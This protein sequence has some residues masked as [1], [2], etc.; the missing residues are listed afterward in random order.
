MKY[1]KGIHTL[2][3]KTSPGLD[4]LRKAVNGDPETMYLPKTLDQRLKGSVFG[5]LVTTL[6]YVAA[7]VIFVVVHWASTTFNI[8]LAEIFNTLLGPLK[9][10]G[11]GTVSHALWACL[12]PIFAALLAAGVLLWLDRRRTRQVLASPEGPQRQERS[13]RILR[14]RRMGVSVTCLLMAGSLL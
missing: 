9:G 7:V 3:A 4:K 2:L 13:K 14:L 8:T 5:Y 10:A 12:P 6:A 11:G 1:S